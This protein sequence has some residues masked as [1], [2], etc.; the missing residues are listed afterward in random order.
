MAEFELTY[1]LKRRISFPARDMKHAAA[2]IKGVINTMHRGL[3]ES[4]YTVL[5]LGKTNEKQQPKKAGAEDSA[6][7]TL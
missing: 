1:T 4:D 2:L 3:S 7:D 6:T 5:S